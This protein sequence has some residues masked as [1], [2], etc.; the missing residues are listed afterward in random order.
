MSLIRKY[1]QSLDPESLNELWAES[2][3]WEAKGVLPFEAVVRQH[4]AL[5][6]PDTHDLTSFVLIADKLFAEVW[7]ECAVRGL[8]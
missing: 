8:R 3:V 6:L 2:D 4:V 1:V 7:R 5:A